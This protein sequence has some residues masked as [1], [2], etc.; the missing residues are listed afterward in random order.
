MT[1]AIAPS[2]FAIPTLCRLGWHDCHED[3]RIH[4]IPENSES[5]VA[6][7]ASSEDA[8]AKSQLDRVA[9]HDV[10]ALSELYESHAGLLMSVI[11]AVLKD[12][13]EAEEILQECFLTIWNKAE[14]YQPHLGKPTSW[15][16]TIAKNKAY[17]RYRKLVRQ[18][19]GQIVLRDSMLIEPA[20]TTVELDTDN[21]RLHAGFKE[22]NADQREAIEMVFFEGLTQQEVADKLDAP[23][24]TVKARIRRGLFKLK[25]FLGN[26][27]QNIHP[28]LN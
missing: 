12:K 8:D 1:S 22:L 6:S 9:K 24:G 18:S 17:D 21:E 14:M 4:M 2:I 10:K 28:N 15:M 23:L 7:L 16:V 26:E 3:K 19:E 27:S 11:Y 13:S 5:K 25:E 20:T